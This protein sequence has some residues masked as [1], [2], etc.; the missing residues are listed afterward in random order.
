MSKKIGILTGGGDCPGLNNAIKW[1]TNA[2]L[3]ECLSAHR[4]QGYE[5]EGITYGWRGA[6][7]LAMGHEHIHENIMPLDRDVVRKIDRDGGTMLG[8]SRTNPFRYRENPTSEPVDVSDNVLKALAER[9]HAVVAIGGEDTLGVAH[10][11]YKMGLNIVGIP[12]TIDK[13]LGGTDIT[14]GFDSA[15]NYI[16]D[17]LTRLLYTAGSH[18]MNYFVEI[19]GRHTGHLAFHGGMAGGAHFILVPECEAD[20]DE[21]FAKIIHRKESGRRSER[22]TIV[23]V[24]EGSKIKGIGEIKQGQK[25]AF[26]HTYLGGIALH[27]RHEFEKRVNKKYEAR[28]LILGHLQRGGTP[29]TFDMI[30]GRHFGIKAIN[31]VDEGKF[32]RIASLRNNRIGEAMLE[33]AGKTNYLD[34]KKCYDPQSFTPRLIADTMYFNTT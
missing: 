14:L 31:L 6:V 33:D 23:A 11:L 27:L 26:G 7:E 24:A 29:S 1:V 17:A 32:G 12:K 19:M 16:K 28:E 15:V 2:A 9:Y 13:D 20:Q 8:S 30:L 3:D 34:C 22:Y 10:R 5:V 4:G 25:D 21:L 18:N